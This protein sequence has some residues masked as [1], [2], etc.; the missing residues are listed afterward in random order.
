MPASFKEQGGAATMD[1]SSLRRWITSRLMS[2]LFAP[3]Q[4]ARRRVKAEQRRQQQRA[5][6][7]VEYFHQIDDGYSHLSA[8]LLPSLMAR[9]AIELDCHLVG[10]PQ[11]NN[12]A[13]PELLSRLSRCDAYLIAP[14]YGL[15]FPEHSDAPSAT[16]LS[17]AAAILSAQ[18]AADFAQ[19]AAPVGAALWQRDATRLQVLAIEYGN[20]PTQ[21]VEARLA[22]GNARRQ[23]LKHYSGAMFYYAGEWYWGVDRLYH[24]EQRLASLGLDRDPGA[25]LLAPRPGLQR[26]S[27]SKAAALTLEIYASL[28][29]PYTAIIFDRAVQLARESGVQLAVR[30]VLPMVMRGV[31]AT[32]EKGMYIF[33]DA[34]REAIASGTP[35]GRFYDP[36][37]NP[38]RRAYALYPWALEN[39]RGIELISSFLR[40]AFVLGVN[41][42]T[43]RGLEQVVSAA[44]LDW[45]VAR[46]HLG[47]TGWE[48][49]LEANRV[50]MYEAGLWGV[51][52][53][54]LLDENGDQ[55]VAVWGQDRLWVIADAIKQFVESVD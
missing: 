27:S 47:A 9:Y 21:R 2:Y 12:V 36:I 39:G 44:G 28:R 20:A 8:Q 42:G 19:L 1:P 5:P 13:E 32:R 4:I 41:T 17:Q 7:T 53:F 14:N 38:A 22:Q 33:M 18:N 16:L 52:S 45:S 23:A 11:G 40:H 26:V 25:P 48:P 3:Q 31:P 43:D 10:P 34:A 30:P 37:G 29:S 50:A 6:H 46:R 15:H 51:P 24:P 49:I 35:Y 54:R 55:R